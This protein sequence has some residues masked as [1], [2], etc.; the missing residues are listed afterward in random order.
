MALSVIQAMSGLSPSTATGF[1]KAEI[2]SL[3]GKQ[4]SSGAS[5]D[6]LKARTKAC[7]RPPF[8]TTKIFT[9]RES[10]MESGFATRLSLLMED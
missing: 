6:S 1:A 2:A 7:S 9:P 8:P 3:P 5:G 4:K 10:N